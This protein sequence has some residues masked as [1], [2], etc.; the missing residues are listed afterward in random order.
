MKL[1]IFGYIAS[2]SSLSLNG[3]LT[4]WLVWN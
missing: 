1:D 2:L 3:R 4:C